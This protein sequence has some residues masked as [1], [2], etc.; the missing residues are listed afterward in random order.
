MSTQQIAKTNVYIE[1]ELDEETRVALEAATD[2]DQAML[3]A[4]VRM[5]IYEIGEGDSVRNAIEMD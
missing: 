2:D 4:M 3:E 1:L 5:A